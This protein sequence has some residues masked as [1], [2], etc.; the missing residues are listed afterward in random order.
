M[1]EYRYRNITNEASERRRYDSFINDSLVTRGEKTYDL[2]TE[3]GRK[4]Y[5]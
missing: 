4:D 1:A 5:G 3:K 2:S